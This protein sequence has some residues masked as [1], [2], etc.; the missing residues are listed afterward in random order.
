MRFLIRLVAK[1]TSSPNFLPSVRALAKSVGVDS[2]A[3]KWTSKGALEIDIFSQTRADFDLFLTI[4]DPLAVVDFVHDLNAA[5]PHKSD[6]ETL[7]EARSY[8]NDERYWECH[9]TLEGLWRLKTGEEKI[10]LQGLILVCA[11]FVHHQKG[12][13]K[14]ALSVLSRGSKQLSFTESSY[15]GIQVGALRRNVERAMEAADFSTFKI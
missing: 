12:E 4:L 11:A 2:R 8:F 5:P 3:A 1:G 13:E 7:V 10:F 14:V 6:A 15:H 9:E